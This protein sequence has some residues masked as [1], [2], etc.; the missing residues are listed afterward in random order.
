MLFYAIQIIASL[1]AYFY[2][3]ENKIRCFSV[4]TMAYF[5]AYYM[6]GS[7]DI[8]LSL[9]CVF[10]VLAAG[11][12]TKIKLNEIFLCAWILL[13]TI[14]GVIF[15]NA[16]ETM[17]AFVTRYGFILIYIYICISDKNKNHWKM[18]VSDCRFLV[19]CGILTE[20]LIVLLVWS[21][22]GIGARVVTN[23]Q[24]IGA[25]FITALLAVVGWGF[26]Q[27]L[28]SA[29]ET[30]FYS[31]VFLVI[32]LLSGTRGYM[33][34]AG[35]MMMV[36][37]LV[38]LLDVP[39]HGQKMPVRVGICCI[40]AALIILSFLLMDQWDTLAQMLRL[41]DSLGYRENEN[42]F[43]REIMKNA[44]WYNV[45][46]GFGMG[47]SANHI[48]GF[49]KIVQIASWNRS[50]MFKRLLKKTLFHNYWY[51]ILF[52][53]GILGLL[54]IIL[55]FV[56]MIQRILKLK[57][58]RWFKGMLV[59]MVIGCMISQTYRITATCL[60]FETLIVTFFIE[61][62]EQTNECGNN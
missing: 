57:T 46:L 2:Y 7:Y 35:M 16:M 12:P 1:F 13:Y 50:F 29:A 55:F 37:L 25:G 40:M 58:N 8:S 6:A 5:I 18:S 33:L 61:M 10:L 26:L 44:P 27:Q 17:M 39:G 51:T 54:I 42:L 45:L 21:S 30:L 62:G 60:I 31:A 3:R 34:I 24:P 38:Y 32:I 9:Y 28:F 22:Q 53:Q 23:N 14:A 11:K 47:G 41:D 56:G 4:I 59:M 43:V 52:K 20:W 48:D 49:L 19:W 36:L 15:Q